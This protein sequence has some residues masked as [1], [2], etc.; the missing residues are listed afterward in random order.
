MLST[1]TTLQA[2]GFR[3]DFGNRQNTT[4]TDCCSNGGKLRKYKC[5]CVCVCAGGDADDDAY[6]A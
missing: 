1:V 4:H 6:S 2:L 3:F 5:M